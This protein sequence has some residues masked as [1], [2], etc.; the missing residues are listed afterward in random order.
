M[1]RCRLLKRLREE[2]TSIVLANDLSP[3]ERLTHAEDGRMF[4]DETGAYLVTKK[5]T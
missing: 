4:V 3:T 5:G 1:K 2:G